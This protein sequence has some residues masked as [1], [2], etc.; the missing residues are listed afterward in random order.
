MVLGLLLTM[1]ASL[2]LAW[3]MLLPLLL[4]LQSLLASSSKAPVFCHNMQPA[5]ADAQ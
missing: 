2:V 1:I 5:A 4:L 3:Q